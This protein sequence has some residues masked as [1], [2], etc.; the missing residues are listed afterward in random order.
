VPVKTR[1]VVEQADL[2]LVQEC[3]EIADDGGRSIMGIRITVVRSRMAKT[4]MVN[5]PA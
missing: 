5:T 3:P 1:R 4:A 2:Q